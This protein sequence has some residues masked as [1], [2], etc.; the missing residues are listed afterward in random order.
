MNVK[1]HAV[2]RRLSIKTLWASR[3]RNLIA[4]AAIALTA[5]LFTSLF[6]ITLSINES[7]QVYNFRQIGGYSHG[8]F[9]DVTPQQADAISAHPKVKEVGMR[10]VIG[11]LSTGAFGK[12]PAEL[13]FMDENC[14]IWSYAQPT[15][16]HLPQSGKEIT[17]DSTALMLLGVKPEIGAQIELT[18]M[19]SDKDT[20]YY[21]KTDTFTLAGWWEYDNISP[22]HYINLSKEYVEEIQE[23]VSAGETNGFRTDLNVMMASSL[24]IRRQM[25]QVDTDLGYT[26]DRSGDENNVRIGVNWGYTSSQ[27]SQDMDIGT[28]TAIAVLL[29]LVIF[30]GY[31]V[32]YNIFQISVAGDIRFYGL[33][34]TIGVTP[35]Q[36]KRII[37]WQALVL[38]AVGIPAGLISGYGVGAL[39]VPQVMKNLSMRDFTTLSTNPLIFLLAALFALITVLMSCS[40][41][42]KIA[43][44]VSPV[45][46]TR[47]TEIQSGRKKQKR[48]SGAKVWKMAFANLGR[49]RLKT[50]LVVIS[51]AL[52]VVML[53]V[54]TMFV[55]GFDMEKYLERQTCADFIVSSSDYFRFRQ[56]ESY[57]S[58]EF[59]Q[60]LKNNVT[61]SLSGSGYTITDSMPQVWME[62][63][64]CKKGIGQF[65]SGDDQEQYLLTRPHRENF[66]ADNALIEGLD[67]Q[68][69]EKLHVVEGNLA[70]LSSPDDHAIAL[71]VRTDDYGKVE[72]LSSY[73]SIGESVTISY[74]IDGY[75]IDRRTGEKSTDSTPEE[76][77]QHYIAKSRDVTYTVCAYVTVPYA[78]GYRYGLSG[79]EFVMASDA[80]EKDSKQT[81]TP[82]YYLFDTPDR[83]TETKAENYLARQTTDDSQLMY[84]S[85]AMLREDFQSFQSMFLLLGG[86]LC[87]I[88]GVVGILNFFN[89]IMTSILSR[90]REFAVL[91][92]V[93]MTNRQLKKML[94]FEGLFFT[95]GSAVIALVLSIVVN[96][97]AGNLLESMFWFFSAKFTILPVLITI[98]V[99]ALLGYLIPSIMYGQS[100]KHSIVERLRRTE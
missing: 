89:A 87:A 35:R 4:I 49:N 96:L 27:L 65:V 3:R 56:S 86:V 62:E 42:G 38:C 1:N 98:P 17:M 39:L 90:Q 76:Y 79:Y 91:Q 47:Y 10:K 88:I 24:N 70:P 50:S 100:T 66:V 13:S 9:K 33:L 69:F 67:L 37:R 63:E 15:T 78:M 57:L 52:S 94:V 45:E 83:Q 75:D 85:K 23:E 36:L 34:K 25:E 43:A 48:T 73:P 14:T 16:G 5:L 30:T 11:F 58:Q 92:A 55:S 54:L 41:P 60:E 28:V 53:N 61:E 21:E 31:L 12:T 81:V 20:A 59:I 44:R 77:L 80:L 2:I 6:T 22:V 32:I 97:L 74:I 18:W 26:W 8:T 93:G 72:D 46:A 29:A 64:A 84:E 68:L 7:N 99:F 51:L 82:L 19:V 40:R 71:V 95:L